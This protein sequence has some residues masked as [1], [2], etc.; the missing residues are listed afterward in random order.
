MKFILSKARVLRVLSIRFSPDAKC[1]DKAG[2]SIKKYLR[3][4]PD[5]QVIFL[6]NDFANMI[7]GLHD[8]ETGIVIKT[9]TSA[10]TKSQHFPRRVG[11]VFEKMVHFLFDRIRGRV[12]ATLL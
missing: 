11:F 12:E 8:H 3:A 10:F 5:A 1:A 7:G 9:R 2:I 4:S 6:G